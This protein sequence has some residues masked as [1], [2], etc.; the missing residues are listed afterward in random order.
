LSDQLL[1]IEEVSQRT[2][3]ACSTLYQMRARGEGPPSF[4][5]GRQRG[6]RVRESA[7]E[8]WLAEREAQEPSRIAG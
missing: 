2:G 1:T 3:L 7:L 6:V 8:A 4:R 5:L